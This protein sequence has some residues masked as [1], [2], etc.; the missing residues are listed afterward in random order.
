MYPARFD[1]TEELGTYPFAFANGYS[2]INPVY[3]YGMANDG[4]DDASL[5]AIE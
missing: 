4:D 3:G 2:C 1:R 5:Q